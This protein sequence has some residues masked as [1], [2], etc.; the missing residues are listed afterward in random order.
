MLLGA[1][2]THITSYVMEPQRNRH[3]LLKRWDTAKLDAYEGCIDKVRASNRRSRQKSVKR[4][5][6][7]GAPSE[8]YFCS[9]EMTS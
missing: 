3:E 9:A 4:R 8:A 1:L 5:V 2:T 6:F 7:A